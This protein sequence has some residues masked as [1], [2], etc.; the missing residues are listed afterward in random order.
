VKVPD[1]VGGDELLELFGHVPPARRA[2]ARHDV[3]DEVEEVILYLFE[4]PGPPD[5]QVLRV[6]R[7]LLN[8][9]QLFR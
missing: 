9:F 7:L 6:E 2:L 3:R 5:L 4:A 1:G 8:D